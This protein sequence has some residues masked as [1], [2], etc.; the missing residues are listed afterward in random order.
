M[1]QVVDEELDDV[2]EELRH[3]MDDGVQSGGA[4]ERLR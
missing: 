1:Q 4:L 3:A 2:R